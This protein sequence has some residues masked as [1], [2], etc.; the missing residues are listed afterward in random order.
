MELVGGLCRSFDS[1]EKFAAFHA[2]DEESRSPCV[3]RHPT[4]GRI[5]SG[6]EHNHSRRGRDT[7]QPRL[8]LQSVHVWHNYVDHCK[9]G[10]MNC[11]VLQKCHW[12]GKGFDLPAYRVEKAARSFED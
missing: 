7:S 1:S 5:I 4:N 3:H 2:F 6:S 9:L 8:H 11:G 10:T 12:I